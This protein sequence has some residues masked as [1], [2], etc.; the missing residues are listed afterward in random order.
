MYYIQYSFEEIT[1]S[2]SRRISKKCSFMSTILTH[3]TNRLKNFLSQ[4]HSMVSS[5]CIQ[6]NKLFSNLKYKKWWL[7]GK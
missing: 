1:F 6:N 5:I 4:Q 2:F 7:D 3:F